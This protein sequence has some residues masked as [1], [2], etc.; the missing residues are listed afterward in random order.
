MDDLLYRFTLLYHEQNYSDIRM[1]R[2]DRKDRLDVVIL[3]YMY[4]FFQEQF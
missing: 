3:K 1:E 4:A 2:E